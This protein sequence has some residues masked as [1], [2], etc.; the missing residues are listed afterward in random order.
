MKSFDIDLDVNPL[1]K[2][3]FNILS[4]E[5]KVKSKASFCCG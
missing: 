5:L 2:E 1:I 4:V 3:N